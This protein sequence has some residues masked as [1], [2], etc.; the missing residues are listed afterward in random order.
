MSVPSTD[1]SPFPSPSPPTAERLVGT[2]R[3]ESYLDVDAAGTTSE[4]PLGPA[5]VGLLHYLPDGYMAVSMM[6]SPAA[7]GDGG[8]AG[9]SG[10]SG[11]DDP[12]AQYETFMGYAGRWRLDGH[13]VVHRAEVSAHAFQIGL[14]QVREVVLDGDELTLFGN[15]PNSDRPQRRMLRWRRARP[16]PAGEDQAGPASAGD[17]Q[18]GAP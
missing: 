16:D 10:G 7:G 1:P 8:H 18:E 9:G 6:R 13:R 2:W 17:D 3:L 14:D 4:G 15:R 11:G 12:A 5:P